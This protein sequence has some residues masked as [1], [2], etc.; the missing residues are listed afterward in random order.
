MDLP[1][2]KTYDLQARITVSANVLDFFQAEKHISSSLP[3]MP[4][5]EGYAL[6]EDTLAFVVNNHAITLVV[7]DDVL[8]VPIVSDVHLNYSSF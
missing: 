6:A 4:T 3:H 1:H 7:G 8:L 2:K 5:R